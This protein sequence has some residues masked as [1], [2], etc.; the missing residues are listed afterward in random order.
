MVDV[1]QAFREIRSLD[2]LSEDW[3]GMGSTAP[4]LLAIKQAEAIIHLGVPRGTESIHV[5]CDVCGGVDLY[6][7]KGDTHIA[8]IFVANDGDLVLYLGHPKTHK[9]IFEDA[10]MEDLEM[11]IER[12]EQ[13][14]L[15]GGL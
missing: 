13:H 7:I 4:S 3:N 12:V 9:G 6:F 11:C 8:G 5:A 2:L 14:F 10:V 1:D 15:E